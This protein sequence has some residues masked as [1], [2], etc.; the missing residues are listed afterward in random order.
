MRRPD[1]IPIFSKALLASALTGLAASIINGFYDILFRGITRYMPAL[2]FNFLSIPLVTMLTFIVLG[3]LFFVFIKYINKPA[4]IVTL[5]VLIIACFAITALLHSDSSETAFYGNH[6]LI[7]GFIVIS[8]VLALTL[9]P[10]L[11]N[12]PKIY[13]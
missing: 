8:G 5:I 4:F 1:T 12:H 6:G 13:I 3:L 2:E 11:Y 9:L 10:Y 7:A